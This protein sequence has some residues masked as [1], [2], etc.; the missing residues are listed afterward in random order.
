[1]SRLW[2]PKG[3]DHLEGPRA[4]HLEQRWPLQHLLQVRAPR[5]RSVSQAGSPGTDFAESMAAFTL[6]RFPPGDI[7]YLGVQLKLNLRLRFLI[8]PE[9]LLFWTLKERGWGLPAGAGPL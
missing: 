5:T 2:T 9:L 1:M 7:P 4:Q 3:L 6:G 8:C